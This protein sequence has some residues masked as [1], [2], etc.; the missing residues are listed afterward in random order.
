[1]SS[2]SSHRSQRNPAVVETTHGR[3]RGTDGG[4]V[5]SFK[6]VRYGQSTAGANR[7]RPPVPPTA[8]AGVQD[9][10]EWGNSAPQ[11]VSAAY[12]DP[13]Y[14]WYSTVRDLSEDCLFLN[15]FT[16]GADVNR[17]PVM[18]WLHGGGWRNFAATAPGTDGSRLAEAEDVVVVTLNHRLGALGFLA[19]G[20]DDDPF[21]D[22]GN[23]GLLDIV[24]ALEW[25]R[26]NIAAFGG[27]P[28]NVTIF[29]QSGGGSKVAALM[30]M[31]AA[32]SLFHRAIIQSS[33][34][35][36]RIAGYEEAE[37]YAFDLARRLGFDSA[38]GSALQTIPLSR[39][40][41][42][43]EQCRSYFR[44]VIDGRTFDQDPFLPAAPVLANDIPLMVGCTNT[45]TTYYMRR[46]PASFRMEFP[47]VK[48]RLTR[49]L[50][51]D[52]SATGRVMEA[53][54]DADPS[55]RPSDILVAVT[56]DYLFKRNTFH[57]AALRDGAA[58]P[59]YAF[60]FAFE[61][62]VDSGILRSPHTLEVPF[63]FGT[64]EAARA[65][66]GFGPGVDAMTRIMTATW[67]QFA[68][69]GDPNNPRLPDWQPY[70]TNGRPILALQLHTEQLS[71]P[72]GQAR[73]ALDELPFYEYGRSRD[74]FWSN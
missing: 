7:F 63:I 51:S 17:R 54:R 39:I 49:F 66:V 41:S 28:G 42:A 25:V 55:A 22:A 21:A 70:D 31:P 37:K 52:D 20:R 38:D 9:A 2:S 60:V 50:Q 27:D 73:A 67:A 23:A 18:V 59:S 33:S 56:T 74:D 5:V 19:I 13:F 62:S 32:R 29:G 57:M 46:N 65:M 4:G 24:L 69:S 36:L 44:P 10:V 34:G 64:T 16:P 48:A 68:R 45:E 1:M 30:A 6:G 71:N 58:A 72:G 35:G 11:Q 26:D 40:M 61:T 14:S 8:W 3:L 47:E 15:V 53:Y 12:S 43:L